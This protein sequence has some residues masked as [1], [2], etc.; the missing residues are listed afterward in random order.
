MALYRDELE[1]CPRCRTEL[2]DAGAARACSTCTGLWI[3]MGSVLEMAV[4]MQTP[5]EPVML[6]PVDE[7]RTPL[8]C[9]ACNEPM[10]AVLMFGVAID[11]CSKNHGVWF[12]A[13][14]LALVLLRSVP[15]PT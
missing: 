5:P 10:R 1:Q 13:H 9:P 8:A 6:S 11:L 7:L 4:Q 12:D 2:I 14:E 3:G 15:E